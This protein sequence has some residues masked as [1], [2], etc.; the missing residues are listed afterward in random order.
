MTWDPQKTAEAGYGDYGQ[1]DR[2]PQ[3][4]ARLAQEWR[5]VQRAFAYHPHVTVTPIQGDPPDVF[6][7]DYRVNTLVV[8]D[9][10][11]L[12]Y[13]TGAS[14]HLWVPAGFPEQAPLMR[15]MSGLFHPNVSYEGIH[16]G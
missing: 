14:V 8:D 16:P 10:G 11:Q 2:S 3:Q 6:Q 12:G 1:G 4:L 13:A 15:P 5:R 9:A 7:V